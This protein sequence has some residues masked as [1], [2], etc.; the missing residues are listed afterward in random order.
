[1]ILLMLMITIVFTGSLDTKAN[2]ENNTVQPFSSMSGIYEPPCCDG[3]GYDPPGTVLSEVSLNRP[4][5]GNSVKDTTFGTT[6]TALPDGARNTYSQLQVWS[7]DNCYMITVNDGYQ[8]RDAASFAVLHEITHSSPRWIPG[9]HKVVSINNEPGRI[10]T[11]DADTGKE[12]VLMTLSQ[13]QYIT[14]SIS[15]EEL[16]RDGQWMSLYIANDGSGNSRLLTVN[17]F[18]KR[19]AMNR[20]LQNMCAPDPEWGL[21]EPDWI[22]VSPNGNY[23][24]VQWVRDGTTMCSGLE[25]YDIETGAFVRRIHTHHAHS[26]LGLAADGR[27]VLV[28]FELAHPDNNNYP[29]IVLYWLDGSP[30]EYL[31]MVPWSRLDHISCQGPAGTW[32]VTAGNDEGDP[33]LKGELYI[34]FQDGSL[35]RIVHHRSDSCD[36]WAQPKAT[37]S[38]DG[39]R[40]AFSSDWR[41]NCGQSGGFVIHN[42]NLVD[43]SLTLTSPN[44]GESWKAGTLQTITWTSFGSVGNVKLEYSTDNGASYS[45]IA[46]STSND[47]SYTWT[48]PNTVSTFCLVKI[49]EIDGS[50]FDVSDGVF[51]IAANTTPVI[52][53]NRSTLT[54]GAVTGANSTG[55]QTFLLGNSGAG[56]LNW[57]LANLTS[58]LSASPGSGTGSAE[59]SVSVNPSGMSAGTYS[60]TITVTDPNASNSPQTVSVTLNVYSS[61]QD[62]APFGIFE[63]PVNGS[64]T[65]SSIPVT[66]WAL[67]DI[68]VESVKIYRLEGTRKEY[69]GDAVFV[70]GARSD[71]ESAYPYYPNNYKAGWGY[72]LLTNFLPNSGNGVFTIQAAATDTSGRQVSLGTKTITCDNAHAVKPFGA[73][74]T[75]TQGG[76]ASGS[77][78]VNWGWALTPLPNKIP[79]NGSTINVWIDGVYVGHPHYNIYRSDIATLFPAYANSNGATG[80]FYLDTTAC[81]NGVHTIQ[82]T[83]EDDAGNTDGIGSRYFTIQNTQGASKVSEF[84]VELTRIPVDYSGAVEIKKGC[85]RNLTPQKKS[86]D[87]NGIITIEI[88]ELQRLE[89]QL[90]DNHLTLDTKQYTGYLVMNNQTRPLPVGSTLDTGRGIF[91]W[92]PGPGYIGDYKFVFIEEKETGELKKR[93]IIVKIVPKFYVF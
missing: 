80:Y 24:V 49:S 58:W 51:S 22:G 40:I 19:I 28:S 21:L 20:R 69:I 72:M 50:L 3:S 2:Q 16:S 91:Y 42:L 73:I 59:I 90:N 41:G 23:A 26:D 39:T 66:G 9:T 74:D 29:A 82:W 63:T 36:Y 81:E 17:L 34:V 45:V 47:G 70:E 64:I 6:I 31:R 85:K 27:E 77:R 89:V 76:T 84:N 10:F 71:V 54:F 68:A 52:S 57:N 92:Q 38:L 33:L 48:V 1:M 87:K 15:F 56:T 13:Y 14:S 65:S 55:P 18:E 43:A 61:G 93:N 53:L 35:R 62:S 25:L 8:V 12:E 7:Y 44:G 75:P 4:S 86:P 46:A 32:L 60:G 88:K 5:A 67:D 78:F 11:Y 30:K 83:A 79:T 37:M